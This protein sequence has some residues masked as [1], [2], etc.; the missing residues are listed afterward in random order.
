MSNMFNG[1]DMENVDLSN[2]EYVNIYDKKLL[3]QLNQLM[4]A[5][6]GDRGLNLEYSEYFYVT[7]Y[8]KLIEEI[9][10]GINKFFNID[11]T[12]VPSNELTIDIDN[13]DDV[14]RLK[15]NVKSLSKNKKVKLNELSK[16][17][18]KS[19]K[20]ISKN[21][22]KDKIK[23][24]IGV[25]LN[26]M[27]LVEEMS[28]EEILEVFKVIINSI[29]ESTNNANNMLSKTQAIIDAVSKGSSIDEV[30][31]KTLNIPS[32][33]LSGISDSKKIML[34]VDNVV[35]G[36]TEGDDDKVSWLVRINYVI[37]L[38]NVIVAIYIALAM[39]ILG[40][41]LLTLLVYNIF[42]YVYKLLAKIV[43][44]S[45]DP[46]NEDKFINNSNVR[47]V[48]NTLNT[49]VKLPGVDNTVNYV[50]MN[51]NKSIDS[52][53]SLYTKYLKINKKG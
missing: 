28:A 52:M 46:L 31:T 20:K 7:K 15:A 36:M 37:I 1:I 19:V 51:Y 33:K 9:N 45:K 2:E 4:E 3:E 29:Y 48:K 23:V 42:L 39:P 14:A 24:T 49:M 17:I 5:V 43:T 22:F 44:G 30:C 16:D 32:D 34:V 12:L 41:G 10:I 53:Y 47:E 26:N 50:K 35:S 11:I 40:Y 8:K 25:N 21:K 13:K 38:F 18:S 27:I 6:T